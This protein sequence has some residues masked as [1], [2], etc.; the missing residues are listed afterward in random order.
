MKQL[1]IRL[2]IMLWYTLS[3]LVIVLLAFAVMHF[4][5]KE[6]LISNA[7]SVI[8]SNC[9]QAVSVIEIENDHMKLDS[10]F[11]AS[12]LGTY[13]QIYDDKD[14]LVYNSA[15]QYDFKSFLPSYNNPRIITYQESDW[16]LFD[17]K[18]AEE[19]VY[20]GWVRAIRPLQYITDTL[21]NM[22][23]IFLIF[24]PLG[25]IIA[26][27]IGFFLANKSLKPIDKITLAAQSIGRG[28]LSRRLKMKDTGDEIGRL[29][30]TFDEMIER[31][32]TAFKKEKQFAS[33]ASHELRTPLSVI[34]AYSENALTG[35][36]NSDKMTEALQV[37]RNESIKM[38]TIVSHLLMLTRG[39]EGKYD[40]NLEQIN[41]SHIISDILE[42]V[43]EKIKNKNIFVSISGEKNIVLYADQTL[44]THLFINI[45]EN[46][47]K[48]CTEGGLI[49]ICLSKDDK[50]TII[51][52]KDN[53]IGIA[54]NDLPN[55]FNR[56]YRGE[57]INAIE[58]SGLGLSIAKW[59][60]DVHKGSIKIESTQ[61]VNTVVS[62]SLPLH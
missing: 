2:K 11:S 4:A 29:S 49:K 30:A 14:A 56:F 34:S 59:I 24:I 41:L 50:Q 20:Y 8:Q 55:V 26:V 36:C 27:L 10:S 62:I 60:V 13:F 33:D 38:N 46:S 19:N 57:H 12:N 44:L 43:D 5:L 17:Q 15:A 25:I 45:I 37:I 47:I 7:K 31:L 48:Y 52:I 16:L 18:I 22:L 1:S 51:Q 32:D 61:F 58:G 3:L 23:V 35:E 21:S 40:L 39:D 53:G 28:D 54:P 9:A 42:V 6:V